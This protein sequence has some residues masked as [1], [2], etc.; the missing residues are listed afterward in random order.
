MIIGQNVIRKEGREKVTGRAQ[1]VDDL[2]F[3]DMMY[4]KTI[5]STVAHGIIREIRFDPAFDWNRV[6]VADYRDIPGKNVVALIENDQPLLVESK[7]RHQ[8]EP[9]LLLAAEDR[10]LL[11]EA[12][13]HIEILYEE[14][15]AVLTIEEALARKQLVYGEN[16]LFKEILI[17]KGDLAKGFAEA[18]FIVEGTYRTG[19]QEHIY[20]ETQGMIALP[21]SNGGVTVMGSL[22]CPYY[23][24]KALKVIFDLPDDKVRVVQTTTGGGFGGKE[25]YPSMI[26]GHA[27]V[28]AH[29]TGRPV[30]IVYDRGEDMAATTKRHPSV[31]HHRTGV[32]KEGRLVAAEIDLL[33]DGGA[34]CTLSPVV[35]SRSAIHSLG[36]YNCPNVRIHARSVATNTPPNGAFRGF[37]APQ[38]CFAYEMHTERI[39]KTLGI[40]PLELRRRNM[41][42]LGD[43]TATGQT[44]KYSV[45]TEEVLNAATQVSEFAIL[46][47][48]YKQQPANERRRGIGMSLFFHGGGFTGSGEQIMKSVAGVELLADGRVRILT[49]STEMGQGTNTIF[50]QIVAEALG[51]NIEDVEME[52]PNTAEVPDSGPTVASRTCMISGRVVQQAAHELKKQ[53]EQFVANKYNVQRAELRHKEFFSQDKTLLSFRDVANEY[54]TTRGP[55]KIF[56]RYE[57]PPEVNWDDKHYRGD[58]YPVYSWGCDVV[59][60]EVDMATY[61][62]FVCKV[63]SAVD[64]GKAINPVL[65]RGQIEGGTLQGFGYGMMEEVHMKDGKMLNDRLTNYMLPTCQ[66]APE[67]QVILIENPYPHGPYGAKGVGELPFNGAAPAL[68]AAICNALDL[69]MTELPF[70][71]ER[72]L[73]AV[74]AKEGNHANCH[75]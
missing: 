40:S 38:A 22:Q 2:Q 10:E 5:R 16:N 1:Y 45:G 20:I 55:L 24:H 14:L 73:E 37:G 36:P 6:V 39:A 11:E 47:E 26:A 60:V 12:A 63:V 42:K 71:P 54:L 25:E 70:T 18:D 69:E 35:L 66:D 34:Y 48:R 17:S 27:A 50:P 21:E 19:H 30:K 52:E 57:S 68:A 29:K 49:G 75:I 9:I 62:V 51:L 44:L 3:P 28:L 41:L 8:H 74:E 7:V 4:G 65:A 58:A 56:Q 64:V 67:M 15:P 23:V 46:H 31:I 61:E 32:T 59:E 13:K 43:V 72:L 33:M 53:L